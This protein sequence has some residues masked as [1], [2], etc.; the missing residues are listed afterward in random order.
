[1]DMDT[2]TSEEARELFQQRAWGECY[3]CLTASDRVSRL[4]GPELEMLA[5]VAFLRGDD[6]GSDDAWSRGYQ[7]YLLTFAT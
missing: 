1:M 2:G 4:E 7:F 6:A 5:T 3:A